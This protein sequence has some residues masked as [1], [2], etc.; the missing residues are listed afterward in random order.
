MCRNPR[1][2]QPLEVSGLSGLSVAWLDLA[3]AQPPIAVAVREARPGTAS[4]LEALQVVARCF[5]SEL[6]GLAASSA[7]RQGLLALLR[8]LLAGEK[9]A[10]RAAAFEQR[11]GGSAGTVADLHDAPGWPQAEAATAELAICAV[12]YCGQDMEPEVGGR[13]LQFHLGPFGSEELIP[14]LEELEV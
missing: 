12:V 1:D 2:G 4:I 9:A 11:L 3:L 13:V 5:P 14:T 7:E 8:H 10:A 6:P